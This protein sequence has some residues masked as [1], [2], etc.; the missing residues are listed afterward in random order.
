MLLYLKNRLTYC[1]DGSSS[2]SDD[3]RDEGNEAAMRLSEYSE[4]EAAVAGQAVAVSVNDAIPAVL[5][6]SEYSEDK[7]KAA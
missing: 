7:A 1:G 3:F 4:D 6:T 5:C 2:S